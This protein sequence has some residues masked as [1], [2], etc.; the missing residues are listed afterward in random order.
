[1]PEALGEFHEALRLDPR[2]ASAH[3]NLGLLLLAAGK[4]QESILEFEA[5]LQINPDFE[6]AAEGLRQAQAQLAPQK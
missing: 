5:A 1:V 6:A 3:S 4:P 2:N